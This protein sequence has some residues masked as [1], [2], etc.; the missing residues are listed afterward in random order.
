VLN[1]ALLVALAT[2]LLAACGGAAAP[3]STAPA[4]SAAPKPAVSAAAEKPASSAAEKPAASATPAASAA[5]EKPAASGASPYSPK[6]LAPPVKVKIGVIGLAPEAGIY[7]AGDKGYFKDEGLD[8]DIEQQRSTAQQIQLM[9]T[10][11][12]QYGTGGPDPALFNANQRDIAVKIVTANATVTQPDDR[13]AA[14]IVRQDL[15]DAGKKEPKDLKGMTIGLNVEGTTS[16]LYT[17]RI[18]RMGGLT[19]N[20]VK[21]TIVPFP[22]QL[23]AF[24]NKG[25]DAAWSV[26]P[27]V[28]TAAARGI[29]KPAVL[30][31]QAYPGAVAEVIMMSPG[32]AKEQP[33]AANRFMVG[34]LRGQREYYRAFVANTNPGGRDEIINILTKYTAI[35]DPK[36]YANIA[37]SG[38]DPNGE[39]DEKVLADMQE[40]FVS[41]GTQ[42]EKADISKIVDHSYAQTAVQRLGRL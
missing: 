33:E 7:I 28:S 21:F 39:L 6:P 8:V 2:L 13:S 26:E 42:K 35:K 36:A 29:A 23:T 18:L 25:I 34:F 4:A 1:R 24:G 17:E 15:Y 14:L 16:Q 27:F 11:Q 19:K 41:N 10:N 22:D 38:A 32:F 9:A 3:A 31:G 12:L 20:D 37:M 30:M 5:A 40:Y